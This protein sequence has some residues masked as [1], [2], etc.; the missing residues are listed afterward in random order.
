MNT[1]ST[2]SDRPTSGDAERALLAALRAGHD[3]T[4]RE[5]ARSWSPS[6]LRV[7]RRHVPS[8]AVAEDVV[9]ETW[10]AVLRGIDRFE[11]RSSLRTWV[12][13]ILVNQ[14]KTRGAAERRTVPFSSAFPD[15]EELHEST[16]PARRTAP[17]DE[18]SWPLNQVSRWVRPPA[19][20]ELDGPEAALLAQETRL[21][22]RAALA[23]LPPRQ[24]QVVSLR[25]VQGLTGADVARELD[26]TEGNQRVLLH[27][28]RGTLRAAIGEYLTAS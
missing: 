12:F 8:H 15:E 22:L 4:F 3:Q 21:R 11:G 7:A 27:R 5:L 2:L 25:D 10:V 14:A 17:D 28:G 23:A 6:M 26:L 16:I 18:P 1:I 19:R 24:R 20:W 9:Q 13:R